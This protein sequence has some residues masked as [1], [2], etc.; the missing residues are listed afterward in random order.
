M[1]NKL[2]LNSVIMS[3]KWLNILCH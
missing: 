1:K 2:R 3:R